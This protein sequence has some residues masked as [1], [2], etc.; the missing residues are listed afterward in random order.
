MLENPCPGTVKLKKHIK[1]KKS[2]TYPHILVHIL[3]MCVSGGKKCWN[4]RFKIRSFP[5]L[6]TSYS[7][8]LAN[9]GH[10]YAQKSIQETSNFLNF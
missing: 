10:F 7:T 3:R 4:T 8:F 9:T 1:K 6:P 5:L 2:L